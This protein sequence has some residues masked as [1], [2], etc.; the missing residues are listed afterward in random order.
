MAL[1][2]TK[3]DKPTVEE[4]PCEWVD[5]KDGVKFK[6]YGISHPLYNL[7]INKYEQR[8][9]REDL[10][11]LN[12][13]SQS[14]YTQIAIVGTYLVADWEG[15][16]EEDKDGNEIELEL[17]TENFENLIL[18]FPDLLGWIFNQACMVQENHYKD[19]LALKK[20]PLTATNGKR[21]PQ[22]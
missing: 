5:Y 14:F 4:T 17:N 20:K 21:K 6:V 10:L 18:N 22:K 16:Y 1:K 7:A 19:L 15:V 11:N 8:D 12:E 3:V 2:I 9:A 13:H